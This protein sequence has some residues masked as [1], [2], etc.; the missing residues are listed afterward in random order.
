MTCRQEL[1]KYIGAVQR[2]V[3]NYQPND[4]KP[5]AKVLSQLRA[6]VA[7]EAQRLG[8]S[9]SQTQVG[10]NCTVG[11]RDNMI[12]CEREANAGDGQLLAMYVIGEY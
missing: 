1:G 9:L 10:V 11:A 6:R 12:L 3:S 7:L 4:H 5:I 2:A 8:G